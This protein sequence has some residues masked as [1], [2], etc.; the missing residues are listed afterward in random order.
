MFS[1]S[2]PSRSPAIKSHLDTQMTFFAESSQKIIDGFQKMNALNMQVA[3]TVLEESAANGRQLLSS[4]SQTEAFS[5][6]AGQSQPAMEKMRAYRQHVRQICADTQAEVTKSFQ[7][8]MPE[9]TRTVEAVTREVSQKATEQAAA[10][11]QRQQDA[12]E[13]VASSTAQRI[14]RATE[15]AINKTPVSKH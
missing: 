11:T 9:S 1:F 8:Y 5:M 7:A 15:S 3:K 14:E 4:K 13:K 2:Q 10:A 12:V 6:M